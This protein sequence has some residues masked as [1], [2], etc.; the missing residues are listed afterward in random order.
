MRMARLIRSLLSNTAAISFNEYAYARLLRFA[1]ERARSAGIKDCLGFRYCDALRAMGG[2][3]VDEGWLCSALAG[4][5]VARDDHGKYVSSCE[6]EAVADGDEPAK[7]MRDYYFTIRSDE[8]MKLTSLLQA[9]WATAGVWVAVVTLVVQ[10]V[11]EVF[12]R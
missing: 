7:G 3:H 5:C 6:L 10:I 4:M 1:A 8:F 2:K 9:E 11:I 12:G